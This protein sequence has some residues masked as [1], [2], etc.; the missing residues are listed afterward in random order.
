VNNQ[1]VLISGA[2]VA[3]PSLALWLGRYG[4]QPTVVERASAI[5]DGGFAVDFR[6]DAH[7]KVLADMGILEDVRRS[8][9][10]MGAVEYVHADGRRWATLPPEILSGE[11]E[12]LR[13]D[14]GRILYERT[15]EDVEYVFGDSI[16]SIEEKPGG[17]EVTF[18]RAGSRS[19]D[20]VVGADGL[21]S[22]VRRLCFGPERPFLHHLGYHVA[23]FTTSND[24]GLDY[25]GRFFNVPGRAVGVYSAR[26]NTEAKVMLV[27]ESPELEVE[28]PD[29]ERQMA[30]VARAYADVGW[31]VP[32]LITA[33][34]ASSDFYFD[35]IS[36]AHVPRW[37]RGRTVLLGDAA[38][39]AT[40]GGMG[41][42]AA[43]V[44]AYV[45]AGELHRSADHRAAY[46]RYEATMRPYA[47]GA[48]RFGASVGRSMAPG[49]YPRIWLRNLTL[50]MLPHLPWK[51][52][53]NDMSMKVANAITLADYWQADYAPADASTRLA[54][55]DV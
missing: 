40:M 34:W 7:R 11:V 6:G 10:N 9:T 2:G 41:T 8:Q 20:L 28:P 42:G 3:G 18:E 12:I 16:T 38:H 1:R 37:S 44:G 27:F 23:I 33:M 52:V 15:R 26:Q 24:L 30:V 50:R 49:S 4:F 31:E 55:A 36:Q 21:H 53:I 14:L 17:V 35:S 22:N 47:I 54:D 39:G 29:V 43:V 48:Q 25:G 46:D 19:F 13:G 45:L 32:R 51:G 5:R